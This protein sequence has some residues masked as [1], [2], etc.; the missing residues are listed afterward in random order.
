MND[1][2]IQIRYWIPFILASNFLSPLA[3][4]PKIN[5]VRTKASITQGT[6]VQQIT[7]QTLNCKHSTHIIQCQNIN[8]K[9]NHTFIRPIIHTE[10]DHYSEIKKKIAN[11]TKQTKELHSIY[12]NV[13]CYCTYMRLARTVDTRKTLKWNNQIKSTQLN[14]AAAWSCQINKGAIMKIGK[15]RTVQHITRKAPTS[16]WLPVIMWY[17]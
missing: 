3:L 8:K 4:I 9:W 12:E 16:C 1:H 2:P 17:S 15:N 5:Q 6:I 14:E 10:E 11:V 7:E 13:A